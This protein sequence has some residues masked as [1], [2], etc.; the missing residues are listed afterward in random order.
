MGKRSVFFSWLVSYLL[1]MLIPIAFA[2][3]I[4]TNAEKTIESEVN[5]TN[6]VMLV[7]TQK[8]LDSGFLEIHRFIDQIQINKRF[9]Q[10]INV[11]R[12]ETNNYYDDNTLQALDDFLYYRVMTSYVDDYFIYLRNIDKIVN[13]GALLDSN[14]YYKAKI[15]NGSKSGVISNEQWDK[16]LAGGYSGQFV[17]LDAKKELEDSGQKGVLYSINLPLNQK[18]NAGATLVIFLNYKKIQGMIQNIQTAYNGSGIVLQKNNN[19]LFST[20]NLQELPQGIDFNRLSNTPATSIMTINGKKSVVSYIDSSEEDLKFISIISYEVFWQKVEAIR[21]ITV[22]CA[23]VCIL[24]GLLVSYLLAKKNYFPLN[25][26]LS[27]LSNRTN[28]PAQKRFNEYKLIQDAISDTIHS[29]QNMTEKL[30]QQT[31][32][33]KLLFLEKLLKGK[34]ND[35]SIISDGLRLYDIKF[36]SDSF[37]VV[38]FYVKSIDILMEKQL[39]EGT[40]EE[41][42][43]MAYAVIAKAFDEYA[44]NRNDINMAEIDGMSVFLVN[45]RDDSKDM[46][47]LTRAVGDTHEF[48]KHN[49]TF[50]FS[51]AVSDIHRT[52]CRIHEAY[53]EAMHTIEYETAFESADITSYNDIKFFS[54]RYNYSIGDEYQLINCIKAGDYENGKNVLDQIFE[55]NFE[56]LHMSYSMLKCTM[57]SLATTM[58]KAMIEVSYICDEGYVEKLHIE[59]RLMGCEK[60]K[61]MK[62]QMT[63]ILKKVCQYIK[64]NKMGKN[65]QL[66]KGVAGYIENNY[67]DMNLSVS[68][69]S[70]NFDLTSSYLTKLFKEQMSEGI[71]D[72]ISKVRI[73]KAKVLLKNGNLNIKEI[74]LKVG[75]FSSSVFIRAF[76]KL[77]GVTPGLY[78]WS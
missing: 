54:G 18:E 7:Q 37:V 60:I 23:S 66:I 64:E 36:E 43:S 16:L 10:L 31:K 56:K 3:M 24:L 75:Y 70:D 32:A 29:N 5:N 52:V 21:L 27:F 59:D 57:F 74:A 45:I 77:E 76:K 78:K 73:E 8:D 39:S 33:T 13:G 58:L 22:V 17:V 34:I 28:Q 25:Q 46:Q 49:F 2:A 44:P 20:S 42:L 6:R 55:K 9:E 15:E 71:S 61:E 72:Y 12:N 19:V 38:I 48:I 35:E 11:S 53:S 65:E 69:I 51:I 40:P 50:Q 67:Q 14:I 47:N 30:N 4:Y 62:I 1:V 63:D 68:Q 26:L 41:K